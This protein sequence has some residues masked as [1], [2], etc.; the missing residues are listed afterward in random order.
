MQKHF[1]DSFFISYLIQGIARHH[2]P[3]NGFLSRP[4]P[5][6][7]TCIFL[8]KNHYARLS[9]PAQVFQKVVR[10]HSEIHVRNF[11]TLLRNTNK[12]LFGGVCKSR[13]RKP[14][15]LSVIQ[16]T[17]LLHQLAIEL[18][19][20]PRREGHGKH[21]A[22][23]RVQHLRRLSVHWDMPVRV[24]WSLGQYPQAS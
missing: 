3:P 1:N 2:L 18:R 21:C 23:C 8:L 20:W 16:A 7:D 15:V 17:L 19:P 6:E 12:K 13:L 11:T 5:L 22:C 14:T 24:P 10:H 4:Y 9:Q